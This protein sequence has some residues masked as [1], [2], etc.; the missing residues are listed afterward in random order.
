MTGNM[1]PSTERDDDYFGAILE[2]MTGLCLGSPPPQDANTLANSAA[3]TSMATSDNKDDNC[4]NHERPRSHIINSGAD[5]SLDLLKGMWIR[6]FEE[7]EA[8]KPRR[9]MLR[10]KSSISELEEL[11][12]GSSDHLNHLSLEHL[13]EMQRMVQEHD[14]QY[15]Q[16]EPTSSQMLSL[17]WM[18]SICV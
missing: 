5:G 15:F 10:R 16:E 6:H 8:D 17:D 11:G 7:Q 1:F 3:D 4:S 12:V 2:V 13:Q 18:D 9:R 14:A